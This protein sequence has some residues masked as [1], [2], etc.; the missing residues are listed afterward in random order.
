MCQ[1]IG[2]KSI[3]LEWVQIHPTGLVKPDDPDAK[4]KFLAAEAL[5]G[6]GGLI[7]DAN[8]KRFANELGRRDYVTGEMWKNKPPFRLCLNKKAG[9]EIIWHCKHYTGRGVMKFY[10]TG[11]DLAKDMGVDVQTLIDTH[12]AHYAAAKNTEKDPDGGSF[13]AYPSGKSWDEASGKT[14]SGKKF[15]HNI[16]PGSAVKTEPFYVAIIT[17]VIHYCMGG[18]EVD[19]NSNVPGAGNKAIPGLYAAGEVAGGIHGNNRLGGNSLLD[20]VVFGRVAGLAA[21]KYILGE[22]KPTSLIELSGGGLTGEVTQ[23]IKLVAL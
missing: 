12:D 2:A 23:S 11:A 20:C 7:F 6:V 14:G 1:A 3:D 4:I 19:V 17:P 18:L 8:G 22:L 13:P 16:L 9:E 15:Y 21:A 10:E 5:R